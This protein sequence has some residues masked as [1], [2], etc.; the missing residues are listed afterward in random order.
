MFASY[1]LAVLIPI[2]FL[3]GAAVWLAGI[4]LSSTTDVIDKRFGFGQVLGGLIFL[5]IATN[6]PEIAIVASAPQQVA[7]AKPRFNRHNI[8]SYCLFGFGS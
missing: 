6:L 5:A 7:W 2:F 8:I 1:S 3:A 4:E